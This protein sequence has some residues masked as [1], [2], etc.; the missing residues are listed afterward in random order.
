MTTREYK[1][2]LSA[3]GVDDA[4]AKARCEEIFNTIFYGSDDERFYTPVGDD[5]GYMEDT[6]NHDAR[7]E[8]M[9]YGMMMCVQLDKK[10]EFDRIWK[11]AKTYMFLEGGYNAGYFCWSNAT[12]GSKNSQGAAPDGEEYFA[13]DLILAGNR[14]GNGKGI[15]NYHEE[16]AKLLHTMLR[17]GT[18]GTPGKPMFDPSNMYIKFIADVDFSDPSYHLPHFYEL[19]AEYAYDEDKESF[20]KAAAASREYW[21]KCCH[22]VTGLS[23]EYGEYDGSPCTKGTEMFGRHDWFYSDAYRTMMNISTD[24]IWCGETAWAKEQAERYLNFFNPKLA[25]GSW[26]DVYTVDGQKVDDMK[27]LHPWAL[28]ASVTSAAV[29]CP[30]KA[31][32]WVKLFLERGLRG[33]D[34]RYYDNCLHF[35]TYMILTGNFRMF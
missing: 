15:F 25:D 3:Y 18:D 5:M 8:G 29:L 21:K 24:A 10:E 14:W 23:P 11:W 27:V 32:G 16:A 31:S 28:I 9:S 26:E 33:G 20:R 22:P 17:K 35:F 19:Y 4:A 13:M 12:D 2:Y 6:G 34:R 30:E 1:N 7:T